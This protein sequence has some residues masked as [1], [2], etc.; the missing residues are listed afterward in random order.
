MRN[1]RSF[2]FITTV[3]LGIFISILLRLCWPS[4]ALG[5]ASLQNSSPGVDLTSGLDSYSEQMADFLIKNANQED[6]T[7]ILDQEQ[8]TR[9]FSTRTSLLPLLNWKLLTNRFGKILLDTEGSF[10]IPNKKLQL[11]GNEASIDAALKIQHEIEGVGS[12]PPHFSIRFTGTASDKN[13]IL[14]KSRE[15]GKVDLAFEGLLLKGVPNY[16]RNSDVAK[17]EFEAYGIE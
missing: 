1:I 6:F 8:H 7:A 15:I 3:I 16:L 14:N 11:N 17:R 9:T 5:Q 4:V 10:H 2:R 13:I 12:L